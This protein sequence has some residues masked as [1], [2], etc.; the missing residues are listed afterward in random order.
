MK[1]LT[2][3]YD[4]KCG[5]RPRNLGMC[6]AKMIQDKVIPENS[7]FLS[8]IDIISK[9][10]KDN[11]HI[12]IM[13]FVDDSTN[14]EIDLPTVS[15]IASELIIHEELEKECH[16]E[17]GC[18]TISVEKELFERY[19]SDK[20]IRLIRLDYEK[21][22]KYMSECID[23]SDISFQYD[24]G[25][26]TY[27]TLKNVNINGIRSFEEKGINYKESH[28]QSENIQIS[29][30][31]RKHYP[32]QF[33]KLKIVSDV[34]DTN[35]ESLDVR[36]NVKRRMYKVYFR[37]FD[38]DNKPVILDG[39]EK[40]KYPEIG[41]II[42]CEDINDILQ[43]FINAGILFHDEIVLGI[44]RFN[45][46]TNIPVMIKFKLGY[47]LTNEDKEK[48]NECKLSDYI[49]YLS[50]DEIKTQKYEQL[51]LYGNMNDIM[52][53]LNGDT[54]RNNIKNVIEFFPLDI[55]KH[56]IT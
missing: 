48:F 18:A 2:F 7:K 17:E 33:D 46:E 25:L 4:K 29:R 6:I 52:E 5:F 20:R 11:S 15:S 56:K 40:I 49:D 14:D 19:K 51:S 41:E 45:K 24:E 1:N 43:Y 13:W 35:Y 36:D 30:Y 32:D 39:I 9:D 22:N 34:I 37:L 42:T 27:F 53:Y 31:I 16:E 44:Y 28:K 12:P 3:I 26:E 50:K 38:N 47:E 55:N 21:F 54:V 8:F 10:E 23:P